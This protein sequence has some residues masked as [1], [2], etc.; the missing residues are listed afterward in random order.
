MYRSARRRLAFED[1]Y[2]VRAKM[3]RAWP[4]PVRAAIDGMERAGDHEDICSC[5]FAD[6]V[7][8]GLSNKDE[9][10]NTMQTWLTEISESSKTHRELALDEGFNLRDVTPLPW[11]AAIDRVAAAEGWFP[12]ALAALLDANIGFLENPGTVLKHCDDSS[13]TITPNVATMI[14]A[15]SSAKKSSLVAQSDR[16]MTDAPQATEEFK[17][18]LI[19]VTDATT[20][21]IRAQLL[22][23]RRTLASSDE[24]TNTMETPWSDKDAGLHFLSKPKLNTWTQAECDNNA[25]GHGHITLGT[26]DLR[27]SFCLK[28][29][30]QP[31]VIEHLLIPQV[32]GFQKRVT[33]VMVPDNVEQREG[34]PSAESHRMLAGL[35]NFMFE[36]YEGTA[37]TLTLS[38]YALTVYTEAKRAITDWLKAHPDTD[39]WLKTKVEFFHSDFLRAA[40]KAMRVVQFLMAAHILTDDEQLRQEASRTQL[41][42]E[43]AMLG[44]R[45]WKRAASM[46]A[47]LYRFLASV[48]R[49]ANVRAPPGRKPDVAAALE[50]EPP[51]RDPAAVAIAQLQ[52]MDALHREILSAAESHTI[53]TSADLRDWLRNKKYDPIFRGKLA[54]NLRNAIEELLALGLLVKAE[55]PDVDD[56]GAVNA[57]DRAKNPPRHGAKV[58]TFKKAAW[59]EITANEAMKAKVDE[60][61]LTAQCFP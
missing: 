15:P 51:V 44:L 1:A 9:V 10:Y 12:E 8:Q 45:K 39:R 31:E 53:F 18:R 56:A 28:L 48:Q 42:V 47:G 11:L 13:H 32:H 4:E 38:G 24:A 6:T 60:L 50:E 55:V 22:N 54:E 33:F 20:K 3:Q 16:W 7:F 41:S 2:Q 34:L 40:H 37:C 26:G 30:G 49:L 36:N 14:G 19:F 43:E 59:A 23:T 21:G 29:A 57:T 61:R 25:T 58:S 27:Y 17:R 5:L 46:H 35:H 52:G